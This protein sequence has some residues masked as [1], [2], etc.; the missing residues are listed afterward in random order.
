MKAMVLATRAFNSSK[1]ASVSGYFGGSTPASRAH[2][3][4]EK[5]VASWTWRV[6]GNMS[7]NKRA[8]SSTWGSIFLAAAWATALSKTADMQGSI[9]RKMGTEARYMDIDMARP[10]KNQL[11][12]RFHFSDF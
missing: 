9:W 7:G 2:A 5:S 11:A 8:A 3:P 4:F 10:S 12:R 6:K 1:V